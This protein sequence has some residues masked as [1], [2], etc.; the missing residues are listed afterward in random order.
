MTGTVLRRLPG[1]ARLEAFS[2]GVLAIVITLLVLEIKVPHLQ[3]P[4]SAEDALRGLLG[5]APKF[6]GYLLSFLFIAVFWINHHRFFQLV[7]RVDNGLLWLNMFLLLAISFVPFPTAMIGEYPW[8]G[9]AL[10]LF[11]VALMVAGLSFHLMWRR[12]KS[13]G[14]LHSHVHVDAVRRAVRRGMVGPA[15]YAVAAIVAF[16]VPIGSW[17]LFVGIP[18]YY[19]LP[20]RQAAS[21]PETSDN[22]AP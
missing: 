3:S 7:E 17:M 10:A 20:H 21:P 16:I 18:I 22:H 8:N 12:A 5:L 2:D 4:E 11:A 19:A 13:R 15:L 1:P 6:L 9:T 14:L